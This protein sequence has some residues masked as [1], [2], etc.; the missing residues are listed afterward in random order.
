M[1]SLL[2]FKAGEKQCHNVTSFPPS[3]QCLKLDCI[4]A[5]EYIGEKFCLSKPVL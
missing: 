2:C 1:N 4:F 3:L 5:T